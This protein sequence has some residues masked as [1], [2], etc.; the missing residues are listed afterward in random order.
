MRLVHR[1]I[2]SS[3]AGPF[4]F[5]WIALTGMLMLNQLAK[6]FG[7]LVGKGLPPEVI[8]EVLIL[9]IPFIVALTLPMAVLVAVL[10]GFTQMGA[11]NELTA[12]RAT[13]VSVLQMLR[14]VLITGALLA[15]ANF[16][17][18]DQI[19]PKTN[20]RLL[21]LQVDIARKKPTF[22][23][24]EQV[25]NDLSPSLYW[26]QASRI[27]PGTG[28]MREVAIYDLSV[29]QGRRIIYADSGYMAFQGEKDL[30]ILLFDGT[31]HEYK[32]GEP[33]TVRV[34]GYSTNTIRVKDIQN[35]L[36]VGGG[37][38][39]KGD[40]EMTTCEMMDRVEI[41]RRTAARA[42]RNQQR[43]TEADLRA[44]LHIV[45]AADRS[46]PPNP[47]QPSCSGTWRKVE[48]LMSKLLLPRK[49][50][51]QAPV[52]SLGRTPADTVAD[53]AAAG[54]L[55]MPLGGA[56]AAD[57]VLNTVTEVTTAREEELLARGEV[58]QYAVEIHKKYTLSIAC[59][60]FVLIGIA[61]ALRFPRGGIGLVIGG[62]LAIFALFYVGLT[63]GESLADQGTIDPALAM[64]LPN[65]IVL[66]L[67]VLG[68][69][70]V[71]K[72]FG[73]TRGGDLSDLGEMLFGWARRR[74]RR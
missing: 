48:G 50:S 58:S 44:L 30:G 35:A 42:R 7:E 22:R 63:G 45:P 54:T 40:R 8:T 31:V 19:L 18:V 9:F 72:E 39:Q 67:G 61:L 13:G 28:R 56:Q 38:V 16:F 71:N 68:L 74:R 3:L 12:M 49:A 46:S 15:V 66:V 60:N 52:D 4:V 73:S 32:S 26:I 6:R 1:H 59:F 65:L 20:L 55:V 36:E 5:A 11:D 53:S 27:E 37:S 2:L 47:Y 25:L 23:L 70:R 62:S 24:V 64:W 51:A 43:L 33:S 41:G 29:V 17:F 10:Y 14:P 57:P 69:V 34:T 21:N